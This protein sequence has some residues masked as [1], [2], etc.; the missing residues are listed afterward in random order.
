MWI[1]YCV[2]GI[3]NILESVKSTRNPLCSFRIPNIKTISNIADYKFYTSMARLK[4]KF[5]APG[6]LSSS[7]FLAPGH[8]SGKIFPAP[9][10]LSG[11]I[12]PAPG[13]LCTKILLT[14]GMP[15]GMVRV[16]IERDISLITDSRM[17]ATLKP[18]KISCNES[19]QTTHIS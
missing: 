18:I 11:K 17:A 5:P 19:R 9:G 12:F 2:D 13:H 10:H 1:F 16:G 6:H 14:P 3:S 4:A 7:F 15:G 8:S